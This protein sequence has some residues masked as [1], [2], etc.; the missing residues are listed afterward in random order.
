MAEKHIVF[1]DQLSLYGERYIT[2]V[3]PIPFGAEYSEDIQKR[4]LMALLF[5]Q[6]LLFDKIAIKID[7]Q[8][9]ELFFLIKELGINKVEE[10]L[11]YGTI[12]LVLWTPTI[13]MLTGTQLPDGSVD[14]S[15]IIGRPP[16]VSG[17]VSDEFSDPEKNI[18]RL[19]GYFN[20]HKER[21]KTFKKRAL[22]QFF[23]P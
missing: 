10:L 20:L 6:F 7:M 21:K 14:Q 12:K 2:K 15:T 17:F 3:A 23:L 9:L 16:L 13:V 1:N 18:E 11:D 5:E 19:L 22:K 4:K 8:N